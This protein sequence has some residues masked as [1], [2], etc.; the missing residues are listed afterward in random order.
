VTPT[1]APTLTFSVHPNTEYFQSFLFLF[2]VSNYEL[3]TGGPI[4]DLEGDSFPLATTYVLFGKSS[5]GMRNSDIGDVHSLGSYTR[6]SNKLSSDAITRTVTPVK[7]INGDGYNDLIIGYPLDSRCL[8]YFGNPEGYTNMKVGFSVIGEQIGDN[9]GWSIT[10]LTDFNGDKVSDFAISAPNTGLVYII[11]GKKQMIP[12]DL[13]IGDFTAFDGIKIIGSPKVFSTGMSIASAGDFN[14]DGHEDMII[15]A[16]MGNAQGVIYVLLGKGASTSPVL[17]LAELENT[18]NLFTI[19]SSPL[20]FAGFIISGLNDVNGDGFDDIV[21]GS[22]PYTGGMYGRQVSYVIFGRSDQEMKLLNRTLVLST[23]KE[24]KDGFIVTGAGFM[25]AGV[26]DVNNDGLSDILLVD[27]PNWRSL[28]TSYTITFPRIITSPPT[29]Q[30]SSFPTSHPTSVPS[31]LPTESTTTFTPSNLPTLNTL[32]PTDNLNDSGSFSP[33]ILYTFRPSPSYA[34]SKAPKITVTKRPSFRPTTCV[35]SQLPSVRSTLSPTQRPTIHMIIP[36]VANTTTLLSPTQKPVETTIRPSHLPVTTPTIEPSL[37]F[38]SVNSSNFKTVVCLGPGSYYAAHS[39][40]NRFVVEPKPGVYR[41]TGSEDGV[42]IIIPFPAENTIFIENFRLDSYILDLT[43]YP[44]IDS[45]TDIVYTTNPL[46][47]TLQT[48]QS[49]I[50]SN[51]MTFELSSKNLFFA[52][53]SPSVNSSRNIQAVIVAVV[54]FLFFG[55]VFVGDRCTRKE[56]DADDDYKLHDK[57][58]EKNGKIL[59]QIDSTDSA[60]VV[61]GIAPE[62]RLGTGQFDDSNDSSIVIVGE[63]ETLNDEMKKENSRSVL[64]LS[65]LF[66]EDDNTDENPFPLS[67]T[68]EGSSLG[69]LQDDLVAQTHINIQ[70]TNIKKAHAEEDSDLTFGSSDSELLA[71]CKTNDKNKVTVPI[72]KEHEQQHMSDGSDLS[73]DSEDDTVDHI[74]NEIDVGNDDDDREDDDDIDSLE[75]EIY[76]M[77]MEM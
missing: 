68:D 27:F 28:G 8:V 36:Q 61:P 65:F 37:S 14:H 58:K 9:F 38:D 42:N 59:Q 56:D 6:V 45:I 16:T 51:K 26:G 17:S 43:H 77:E 35:P 22:L 47:L 49:V 54:G 62:E 5:S 10:S 44:S 12:S 18:P 63:N 55:F 74:D 30:P 7:D 52:A 4:Y 1:V 76:E 75:E 72:K 25:V 73:L 19:L 32:P 23:L 2:G 64:S 70:N 3:S 57:E 33:T 11:Y 39:G 29:F 34:P 31:V 15:S 69:S 66:S 67:I 71:S 40:E 21:I 41:I 24:G 13:F 50:I 60:T 48:N 20:S 53:G 46:T